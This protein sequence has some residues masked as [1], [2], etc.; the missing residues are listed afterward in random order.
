MQ[1]NEGERSKLV[2]GTYIKCS[3]V[4]NLEHHLFPERI[5]IKGKQG[6][7]FGSARLS[8]S[9]SR[10]PRHGWSRAAGLIKN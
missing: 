8:K 5:P 7:G 10:L 3:V 9:I 2:A 1:T 6:S 4:R